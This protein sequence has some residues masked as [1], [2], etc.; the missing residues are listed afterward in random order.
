MMMM[1]MMFD[2]I[3]NIKKLDWPVLEGGEGLLCAQVQLLLDLYIIGRHK[4]QMPS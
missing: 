2:W 1:M 3:Y 4:L